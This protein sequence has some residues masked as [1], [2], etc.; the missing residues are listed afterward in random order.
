[1]ECLHVGDRFTQTGNDAKAREVSNTLWVTN[2]DETV[3]F[4]NI[5]LNDIKV[6]HNK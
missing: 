2:P 3:E 6:I 1:M 4:M 5:L